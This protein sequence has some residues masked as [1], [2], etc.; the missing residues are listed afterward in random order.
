MAT[1]ATFLLAGHTLLCMSIEVD[2]AKLYL[3]AITKNL[4][5]NNEWDPAIVRTGESAPVLKALFDE[6]K[7][8]G[9]MRNHQEPVTI[10][11]IEH[12]IAQAK[13]MIT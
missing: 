10:E 8:W 12:I 2:T 13:L 4:L 5:D 7:R 1:Y 3:K 11:M 9:S 6:D